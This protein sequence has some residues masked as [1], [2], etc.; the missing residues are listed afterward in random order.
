[1]MRTVLVLLAAAAAPLLSACS[2]AGAAADVTGAVVSTTA[3]VISTAAS[4][5]SGG[6]D[7]DSKSKLRHCSLLQRKTHWRADARLL[8][9]RVKACH[10]EI[11]PLED[12]LAPARFGKDFDI[13][14]GFQA[15]D[16]PDFR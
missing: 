6:S 4:T 16:S 13:I 12:V 1:M 14:R 3:G 7:S 9:G 8:G 10:G 5:V 11:G 2:V 15:E